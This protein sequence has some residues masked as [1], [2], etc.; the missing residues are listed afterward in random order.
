MF[1]LLLLFLVLQAAK[2]HGEQ[3]DWDILHG[4]EEERRQRS[5]KS[6]PQMQIYKTHKQ[7]LY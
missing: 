1:L 3:E 6:K 5:E 4:G 7:A 2:C